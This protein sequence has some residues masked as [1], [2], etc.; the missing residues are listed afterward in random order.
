MPLVEP[1]SPLPLGTPR[2]LHVSRPAR[3]RYRFDEDLFGFT[4]RALVAHFTAA[5]RFAAAI[6]AGR[7]ASR[8]PERAV[9]VGEIAAVGLVDEINHILLRRFRERTDPRLLGKALA[10]FAERLGPEAVARTLGGFCHEFPPVAVY[11]REQE[12]GE[13]LAG[14]TGGEPHRE[15]ALE[16]LVLLWLNNLNPAFAR[17]RELFD[18][19]PLAAATPYPQ[20]VGSLRE[21]F[22]RHRV[23]DDLAGP[24]AEEHILDLLRAPALAAPHSAEA[25]LRLLLARFGEI[26]G[27]SL[28]LELLTALDVLKEE[29]RAFLPAAGGFGGAPELTAAELPLPELGGLAAEPEAFTPDR[30]WMPR[31]VLLAKNVFVWLDQLSRRHGRPIST[32]AEVPDAELDELARRGVTGLWLIGLWE[33]SRASRRIKQMMGNPEAVASAYSLFDYVIAGELGGEAALADLSAR[34]ARRGIRLASDMVPNHVGIDGRWVLEHPEWFVQLPYPPFPSYSFDGPDLSPDPGVGIHLEDHYYTRSD[35]A[36][37]FRR[38]D[39]RTGEVR[40]LYHGNDGTHMP[41]NDTAQLDYLREDVRE[42]AMQTILRVARQFPIVRFDAAMTLAKRHFQRLWYPEPG[43]GGDIPSRAGRGLTRADF[44]ARMPQEFWREVVDRCAAETPD[45]LLLAE[46]FWLMEGY[47]VRTLGMHRVYNSAFMVCLRDEENAKYRRILKDTLEFD[48]EILYRFVNFASNPDERTAVDQFGKGDKYFGVATLMATL[49]GLPMFGHGQVEGFAERYGMEYRRAYHDEEPDPWLLARHER[50]VFPLL[51]RRALFSGV[52]WFCLYDLEGDDGGVREDVYALSNRRGAERVLV[53]FNNGPHGQRGRLR[54]AAPAA[55]KLPDGTKRLRHRSLAEGLGLDGGSDR[56]LAWRE[57]GSG[58]EHLRPAAEV[59]ARGFEI[60][61]APY[62][63]RVLLDLR[64]LADPDGRLHALA[65]ELG[66]SGVPSLREALLDVAL[67]P[68]HAPFA[69]LL[70][71]DLAAALLAP[72][73]SPEDELWWTATALGP[74]ATEEPSEARKDETPGEGRGG[75]AAA[76]VEDGIAR[77]TEEETPDEGE[78]EPVGAASVARLAD[79]AALAAAAATTP[80]PP[81]PEVP[82]RAPAPAAGGGAGGR[83][84][85]PGTPPVEPL[86]HPAASGA[87]PAS[88][89]TPPPEP[90]RRLGERLETFLAAA[91]GEAGIPLEERRATAVIARV[92]RDAARWRALVAGAKAEAERETRAASPLVAALGPGERETALLAWVLVRSLGLLGGADGAGER[93]AAW[94]EAWRLG[95]SAERELRA[96]GLPA[97]RAAAAVRAIRLLLTLGS[98]GPRAAAAEAPALFCDAAASEPGRA[99]LG[100]HAFDGV[101]WLRREG[102]EELGRWLLLAAALDGEGSGAR[103]VAA[104]GSRVLAARAARAGYRLEPLLA[105]LAAHL[106]GPA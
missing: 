41:W 52:E 33:R 12:P 55:E 37:V 28:A 46:A 82:V 67:R 2:E 21:A 68:L 103:E 69:A 58:L 87:A 51:H 61:L 105:A 6:N 88:T 9:S 92:L 44:D 101:V 85:P 77:A 14:E 96:A 64:E 20:V 34:A 19:T 23:P 8:H 30:E 38:T 13:W 74:A 75:P 62:Q 106:S 31:L 45:T 60:E 57:P 39:R 84:E 100:I 4:G 3:D 42:A 36:V 11:R 22:G 29:G 50:E 89:A 94:F 35:A 54:T 18:D 7:E 47:F 27:R 53:L 32:L 72:A 83:R 5:R 80:P 40:Y 26:I 86:P 66:G 95:R 97:E 99:L 98:P 90:A 76:A 43:T 63:T 70:A 25:Q 1:P 71:P 81:H 48:P 65:A 78:R 15:A 56:V 10:L 73:A 16:E 91:A 17:H 49:P 93:T 104:A 59:A 24:D 102:I 79:P